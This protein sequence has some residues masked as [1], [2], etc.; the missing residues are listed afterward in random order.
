MKRYAVLFND[1]WYFWL[2]L[3]I[4]G[5][6]AAK[7]VSGVFLSCIPISIFAFLYF[8]LMR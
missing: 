4:A 7:F 3:N 1:T 8:G 2:V 6:L 5:L